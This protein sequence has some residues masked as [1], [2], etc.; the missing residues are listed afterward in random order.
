MKKTAKFSILMVMS[1]LAIAACTKKKGA[2]L[3]VYP[4]PATTYMVFDATESAKYKNGEI[5][6]KDVQGNVLKVFRTQDSSRIQWQIDSFERGVYHYSY[7]ADKMKEQTGKV[8]F[9]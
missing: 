1:I 7:T 2:P 4:N 5:T 8:V 9:E 6:V 3:S